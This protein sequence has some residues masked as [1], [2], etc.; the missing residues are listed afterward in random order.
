MEYR[1]DELAQQAGTTSRNIRAH[2][3]RGL[4]PPPALRGRTGWYG[5]THLRRLE[6]IDELQQRGFS[7]EAIRQIL[8]AWSQGGDLSQLLGF[9]HVVTAP[10]SDEEPTRIS[11]ADL[12]ERFPDAV[13]DPGL[14]DRAVEEGLLSPEDDA[15]FT[16]PSP[17]L[18][19]AGTELV[20]AGIPLQEILDLV[21]AVRADV[22]DVAARFV[23]LVGRNL[24]DP[25]AEGRA[26][27][28]EIAGTNRALER[29]PPIAQEVVRAFLAQEMTRAVGEALE[30]LAV[31]MGDGEPPAETA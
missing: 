17:V 21:R 22:A 9:H 13:A 4:L 24:V 5:E 2:Q 25:V 3:A 19:E 1:I 23:D 10:F 7:L 30:G 29:L 15:A 16:V 12:L 6:L 8:D 18:I 28:E 11:A 31:R 27:P 26:G 20:R 14:I